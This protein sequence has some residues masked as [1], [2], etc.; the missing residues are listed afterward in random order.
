MSRLDKLMQKRDE[1]KLRIQEERKADAGRRQRKF[2]R[3]ARAAGLLALSEVEME[4]IF[5]RLTNGEPDEQ[6]ANGDLTQAE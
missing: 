3:R 5:K 6:D 2:M 1:L 4:N